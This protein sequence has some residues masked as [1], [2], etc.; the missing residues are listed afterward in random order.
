MIMHLFIPKKVN[1]PLFQIKFS[2]QH[3]IH[4]GITNLTEKQLRLEIFQTQIQKKFP[5][6]IRLWTGL[7][8][9]D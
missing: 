9:G 1:L 8:F 7:G 3:Y 4:I 2:V 6:I 5:T